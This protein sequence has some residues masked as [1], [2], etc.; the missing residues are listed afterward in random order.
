[1]TIERSIEILKQA[2]LL[3][4]RGKSFYSRVAEHTSHNA[5]KEFFT[6]MAD[7]EQGHINALMKQYKTLKE[8]GSF[9]DA[10]F[11]GSEEALS[12][13]TE[14]INEEIA[15]LIDG[16]DY[17]SAAIQA[18]ISMEERAVK[19]YSERAESASDVEEAKLYTWLAAWERKHLH[20]LLEIDRV[21]T[22]R[23]WNDNSFW[24]F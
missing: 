11:S 8:K 3:E 9:A 1:M 15:R 2:L 14:V 7:E 19:V 4:K 12:A 18:A 6:L 20:Q 23:I 16:A 22:E 13:A 10:G 21:V 17:E 24:P 5:V